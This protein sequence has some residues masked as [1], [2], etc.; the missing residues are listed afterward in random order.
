MRSAHR[1]LIVMVAAGGLMTAAS[2]TDAA[3]HKRALRR[4][5]Y[6]N[7]HAN[8]AHTQYGQPVAVVVPPTANMQTNWGWGVSSSRV[9]R[10]DHQFGRNYMGPGPF[11]GPFRNTPAWP[12]DT[13]QFGA[14]NVRSVW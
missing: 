2:S 11:G 5:Q 9:S 4:A 10:M 13:N 6:Y 1:L 12:Q 7:W 14:Y 3:S 8:Y